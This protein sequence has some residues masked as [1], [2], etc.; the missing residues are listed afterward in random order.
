MGFQNK[1]LGW[2][3]VFR[4]FFFV[5][6]TCFK[7]TY[8][9]VKHLGIVYGRVKISRRFFCI[10]VTKSDLVTM[11]DSLYTLSMTRN[12]YVVA[13]F[14]RCLHKDKKHNHTLQLSKLSELL[15]SSA[16]CYQNLLPRCSGRSVLIP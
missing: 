6:C 4:V 10:F 8:C 11:F 5:K 2:V 13:I 9:L 3:A 14:G 15:L 12:A 1:S 16:F 7:L